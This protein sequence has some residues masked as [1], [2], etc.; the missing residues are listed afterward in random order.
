MPATSY[1]SRHIFGFV[2]KKWH[3]CK[4]HKH[5]RSPSRQC[6]DEPSCRS[7]SARRGRHVRLYEHEAFSQLSDWQLALMFVRLPALPH[8]LSPSLAE[9]VFPPAA[10]C[11]PCHHDSYAGLARNT[12]EKWKPFPDLVIMSTRGLGEKM[13]GIFCVFCLVVHVY[14]RQS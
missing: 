5:H 10:E 8:P 7:A 12:Q 11:G 13:L 2:G 14:S 1:G 9:A 3:V 4:H 6:L